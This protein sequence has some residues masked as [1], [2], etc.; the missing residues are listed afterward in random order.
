MT[1]ASY[2]KSNKKMR[3]EYTKETGGKLGK[4]LTSGKNK[5]RVSFACRFAGMKGPME[6]PNGKPTRKAIALEKWGFG[7]VE[8]AKS[9]CQSNKE[10]K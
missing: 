8:A 4:R 7:S 1:N 9:F 5:R 2:E 10:K 6:K 3:S